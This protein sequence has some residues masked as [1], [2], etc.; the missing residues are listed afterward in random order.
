MKFQ[1]GQKIKCIRDCRGYFTEGKIYIS[2]GYGR[3]GVLIIEQ[4]DTDTANSWHEDF[5]EDASS[6]AEWTTKLENACAVQAE[7]HKCICPKENFTVNPIGCI[8]NGI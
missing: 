4:D 6:P 5:F 1:K 3:G 2:K 7:R 8:C